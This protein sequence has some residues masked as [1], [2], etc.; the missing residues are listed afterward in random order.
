M[1]VC[2][3]VYENMCIRIHATIDLIW[4]ELINK[5]HFLNASNWVHLFISLVF[6]ALHCSVAFL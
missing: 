5:L 6:K 3:Y 1:C 2:M 4:K